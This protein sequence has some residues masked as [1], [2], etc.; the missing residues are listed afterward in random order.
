MKKD[1]ASTSASFSASGGTMGSSASS[2]TG[3]VASGM[4]SL[5]RG[6]RRVA[7]DVRTSED[8]SKGVSLHLR[9]LVGAVIVLVACGGTS[10]SPSNATPACWQPSAGPPP[11]GTPA[12]RNGI[13]G[14]CCS[15]SDVCKSNSSCVAGRCCISLRDSGRGCTANSDCCSG[16]CPTQN[17]YDAGVFS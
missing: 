4:Q 11:S 2:M 12:E 15:A 10:A 6:A 8:E 13:V 1:S 3:L 7:L 9:P 14:Q 17:D 5:R 16:V